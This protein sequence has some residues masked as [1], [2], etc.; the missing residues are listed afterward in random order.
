M[1]LSI[2]IDTFDDGDFSLREVPYHK[3]TDEDYE[4][5]YE[6]SASDKNVFEKIK[7]DP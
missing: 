4:K 1:R 7:N 5:F 3:C 6:I 2:A